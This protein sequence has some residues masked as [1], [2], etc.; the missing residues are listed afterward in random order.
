MLLGRL[1]NQCAT[2]KI[3]IHQKPVWRLCFNWLRDIQKDLPLG[4]YNIDDGVV[5]AE[6]CRYS[7]NE[8]EVRLINKS[9]SMASIQ[10]VVEGVEKLSVLSLAESVDNQRRILEEKTSSFNHMNFTRKPR[11]FIVTFPDESYEYKLSVSDG[12]FVKRVVISFPIQ[13]IL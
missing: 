10:Y 13:R 6:C 9:E 3:L 5:T 7:M 12:E 8:P 4:Q 2:L 1:D 11:E